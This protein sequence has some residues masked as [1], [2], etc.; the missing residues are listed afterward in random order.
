MRLLTSRIGTCSRKEFL[1]WIACMLAMPVLASRSASG[2]LLESGCYLGS[3]GGYEDVDG[4][5]IPDEWEP[6]GVCFVG[7]G[8]SGAVN[9]LLPCNGQDTVEG[10]EC[11][12]T[13]PQDW[14]TDQDPF[15]DYT[16]VTGINRSKTLTPPF[17]RPLVAG[18]PIVAIEIDKYTYSPNETITL[19]DGSEVSS[20]E[21]RTTTSSTEVG[22]KVSLKPWELNLEGSWSTTNTVSDATTT[23][24]SSNW[25][26]AT[27]SN[28]SQAAT[29]KL[30]A[31]F[32]NIGSVPVSD[33]RPSVTA[34]LGDDSLYSFTL[35]DDDAIED[36][37]VG[38]RYPPGTGNIAL[39]TGDET[40]TL[41]LDQLS[42]LEAG[43]YMTLTV[44][45]IKG[46]I[47]YW[48][49]SIADWSTTKVQNWQSEIEA[50]DVQFTI[51]DTNLDSALYYVAAKPSGT[52]YSSLTVKDVLL[53][54]GVLTGPDDEGVYT[55]QSFASRLPPFYDPS[56]QTLT[57]ENWQISIS[58][59]L[60]SQ[61]S[62]PPDD[63]TE[64]TQAML[65]E[66]LDFTVKPKD[67]DTDASALLLMSNYDAVNG[68]DRMPIISQTSHG[69]W[70]TTT[71]CGV[72]AA[73]ASFGEPVI[74]FS[75]EAGLRPSKVDYVSV[76][77]AYD[78]DAKA[79]TL[80]VNDRIELQQN[81]AG[82]FIFPDSDKRPDPMDWP[83][84]SAGMANFYY[85]AHNR[86][87]WWE[88]D[89][90]CSSDLGLEEHHYD[91]S[92]FSEPV[93]YLLPY[94]G[95]TQPCVESSLGSAWIEVYVDGDNPVCY[96][97]LECAGP[98]LPSS[99]LVSKGGWPPPA[100]NDPSIDLLTST[101][102]TS[103]DPYPGITV[104]NTNRPGPPDI[105]LCWEGVGPSS[106]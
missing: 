106:K 93:I 79:M 51:Y 47:K 76:G 77:A 86:G 44:D 89:E 90:N 92:G 34:V 55:V 65:N 41:T 42:A 54:A 38:E 24:S 19:T 46:S 10:K 5:C 7:A 43:S 94:N 39:P 71:A 37:G 11:F 27:A 49:P 101:D 40:I 85:W 84:S 26:Q 31:Y 58:K 60:T 102:Q 16:E 70:L 74:T 25:S 103:A 68:G 29:L 8:V 23:S 30:Q 48:D 36:L 22:G 28:P 59:D 15:D 99:W 78:E 95:A 1:C 98:Y 62:P 83:P 21:T 13:S 32:E 56:K 81:D 105:P 14:S 96:S 75:P 72:D 69:T 9:Q 35:A 53:E 45:Q 104:T 87:G 17:N 2:R 61:Y 12:V 67:G 3:V 4:D 73:V 50:G 82:A 100:Y 97:F 91:I 33:V 63:D 52:E 20:S 88:P 64:M 57:V 80:T 18:L 6:G 66:L